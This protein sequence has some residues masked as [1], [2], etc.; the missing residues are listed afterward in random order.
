[1]VFVVGLTLMLVDVSPEPQ[2]YVVAP[3]AE[4][5]RLPPAQIDNEEEAVMVGVGEAL[6]VIDSVVAPEQPFEVAVNV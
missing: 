6:T 2:A 4:R 1:M 5:V 3:E